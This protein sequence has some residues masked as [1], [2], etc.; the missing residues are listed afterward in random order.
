MRVG[1]TARA[2]RS[3][4]NGSSEVQGARR[5]CPKIRAASA[6]RQVWI[7]LIMGYRTNG[8]DT[9]RVMELLAGNGQIRGL[10]RSAQVCAA[11]SNAAVSATQLASRCFPHA[12]PIF[13]NCPGKQKRRWAAA[14]IHL[15][16]FK[17]FGAGDGIR[18]HDPNLGKVVLYP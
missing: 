13:T 2:M 4:A 18:T 17:K 12:S 15:N 5:L 14:S 7:V 9:H 8:R 11:P 10:G 16:S 6:C 3:I 1:G